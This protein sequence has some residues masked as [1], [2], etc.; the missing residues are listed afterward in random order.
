MGST[1]KNFS[2]RWKNSTGTPPPDPNNPVNPNIVTFHVVVTDSDGNAVT[3]S[4]TVDR[5]PRLPRSLS[6]P[7]KPISY[8]DILAGTGS[9]ASGVLNYEAAQASP[10]AKELEAQAKLSEALLQQLDDFIDQA[11]ARLN[12]ASSEYSAILDAQIATTTSVQNSVQ[13]A[14]GIV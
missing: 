11:I 3:Q 4:I 9:I 5:T 12:Q 14:K 7:S 1:G 2:S 10:E 13:R 6:D 8:A